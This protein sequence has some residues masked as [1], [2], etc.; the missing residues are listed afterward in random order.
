MASRFAALAALGKERT[1][2]VEGVGD[3]K[4]A[5]LRSLVAEARRIEEADGTFVLDPRA[6]FASPL[7]PGDPLRGPGRAGPEAAAAVLGGVFSAR[8][9]VG[10]P[11]AGVVVGGAESTLPAALK[12]ATAAEH[13]FQVGAFF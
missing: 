3:L 12:A 11:T 1:A 13:K 7:P 4:P 5:A 9:S 10:R 2:Y 8:D 6:L